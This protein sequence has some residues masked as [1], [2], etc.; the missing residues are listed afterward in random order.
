[1]NVN[2]SLAQ[3]RK[4]KILLG[5]IPALT[6][7]FAVIFQWRSSLIHGDGAVY[8]SLISQVFHNPPFAALHWHAGL[9][10]YEHPYFFF[11]FGAPFFELGQWLG[12]SGDVNVKIPN[13]VVALLT[14]FFAYQ[15]VRRQPSSR[16]SFWPNQIAGLVTCLILLALTSYYNQFQQPTLDPLT[17]LFGFLS[18]LFLSKKKGRDSFYAGIF[19]GLAVITK[20]AEVAPYLLALFLYVV[21]VLRPQNRIQKCLQFLIGFCIPIAVWVGYDWIFNSHQW[22]SAYVGRQFGSRFFSHETQSTGSRWP[23]I[24]S[25]FDLF[26]PHL[27]LAFVLSLI[28]LKKKKPLPPV[29]FFTL[30]YSVSLVAALALIKKDSS[31]HFTGLSIYFSILIGVFLQQFLQQ[32]SEVKLKK[33]ISITARSFLLLFAVTFLGFCYLSA[34]DINKAGSIAWNL[35]VLARTI[36]STEKTIVFVGPFSNKDEV[37]V[38]ADWYFRNNRRAVVENPSDINPQDLAAGVILVREVES[39]NPQVVTQ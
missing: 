11:Y 12:L 24:W 38:D 29:L 1:M 21:F 13:Y 7:F 2:D 25:F 28:W 15:Y 16:E 36:P 30:L 5:L 35:K 8:A 6:F 39:K 32:I 19:L 18:F 9:L 17:H 26:M 4:G 20:G 31:Q 22:L 33:L 27:I 37:I 34:V 23:A 14:L 3:S 10:F